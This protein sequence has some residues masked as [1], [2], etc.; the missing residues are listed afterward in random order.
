MII[1]NIRNE[2]NNIDHLFFSGESLAQDSPCYKEINVSSTESPIALH[3]S[4]V[5]TLLKKKILF[6]GDRFRFNVL[7]F[8]HIDKTKQHEKNINYHFSLLLPA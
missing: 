1:K 2:K 5:E 8:L 4:F 7:A 6:L 3:K